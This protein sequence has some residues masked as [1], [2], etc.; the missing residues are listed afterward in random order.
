M[1]TERI[2]GSLKVLFLTLAILLVFS[3]FGDVSAFQQPNPETLIEVASPWSTEP[4]PL[5]IGSMRAESYPGS[6]IQVEQTLTADVNYDR[7][8][9]SYISEG[10]KI[11][12][13][14]T[15]PRGEPPVSGWPV[16]VFNHGYINPEEYRTTERYLAY[17][18][19]IARSGYIVFKPDFRGHGN[20]GGEPVRGGG[21]GTPGYTVDALNALGAIKQLDV[22]DSERIGFWGHSMGG[23]VTLRAMAVS[24]DIKAGVIWAGVVAPYPELIARW[25]FQK[26]PGRFSAAMLEEL[27]SPSSSRFLWPR[28]FSDWANAFIGKYGE[29]E[30]NPEFWFTISPNSY[31]SDLSG[32]IQLHHS[33]DDPTVPLE[34]TMELAGELQQAGKFYEF[35]IYENDNH[36]IS[37]NFSTAMRQ[38]IEFFDQHVKGQ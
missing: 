33:S 30:Q 11:F 29:P 38:T 16:I 14:M 15:I 31:L 12:A 20:S 6:P 32:P 18:D 37:I 2:K 26:N 10:N 36:N 19:A 35:Y 21:Y 9:V 34:W 23:Q 1:K 27:T 3:A 22:A 4:D 28:D 24:T 25:D 7:F 13:L 8:L 17:V 5:Q